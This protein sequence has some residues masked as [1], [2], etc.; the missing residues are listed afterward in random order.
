MSAE[1]VRPGPGGDAEEQW[2]RAACGCSWWIWT[3]PTV[4]GPQGACRGGWTPCGLRQGQH[5]GGSTGSLPQ[6]LPPGRAG[7]QESPPAG[8]QAL[9]AARQPRP[10][11]QP[12]WRGGHRCGHL[13]PP[14]E[15][16]TH[17]PLNVAVECA[18]PE[19]SVKAWRPEDHF[20][21]H[22]PA[23]RGK[24]G[25]QPLHHDDG[26]KDGRPGAALEPT[27]GSW[28]APPASPPARARGLYAEEGPGV[29]AGLRPRLLRGTR[30]AW[31][32]PCRVP[33]LQAGQGLVSP[34]GC[35]WPGSP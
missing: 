23:T 24:Q 8:C 32:T 12:S 34:Q 4:T 25:P 28:G 15:G 13:V 14:P 6:E 22:I 18:R 35:A 5:S 16:A 9:P 11:G 26:C 29:S 27:S 2:L 30:G 31:G 1:R 21:L 33:L 7:P 10:V 19:P 17:V 3:G 20:N